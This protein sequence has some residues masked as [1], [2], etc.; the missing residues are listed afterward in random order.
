M[1]EIRFYGE[2]YE[3][4]RVKEYSVRISNEITLLDLILILDKNLNIELSKRV[5]DDEERIK[6]RYVV[7]IN[8]SSLR[9][10]NPKNVRIK[11][12]DVIVFLP[13]AVGG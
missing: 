2:L 8:G 12:E 13:P 7:L 10:N 9:D 3:L 5:L 4:T 11:D 1:V 6:S